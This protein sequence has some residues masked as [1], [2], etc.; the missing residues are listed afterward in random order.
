MNSEKTKK[1]Q[2]DQY[3]INVNNIVIL[4]LKDNILFTNRS[5]T[6]EAMKLIRNALGCAERTAT[7]YL[8]AA[9]QEILKVTDIQK[10]NAI[11]EALLKSGIKM[12]DGKEN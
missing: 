6:Q 8:T 11:K 4:L 7:R 5:A 10:E 12:K 9:R 3:K 2:S 1:M